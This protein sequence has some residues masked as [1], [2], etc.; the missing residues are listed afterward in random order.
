MTAFTKEYF[1]AKFTAIPS[2]KI[3]THLLE[4]DG[5]HCALGHCG[6]DNI[7]RLTPE[8]KA[9][10]RLLKGQ[11]ADINNGALDKFQ[12]RTAKARILAALNDL[13]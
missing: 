3:I 4:N 12:N 5:A 6:V 8:A 13:P 10:E 9:L 11:T 2:K 1:I 7:M